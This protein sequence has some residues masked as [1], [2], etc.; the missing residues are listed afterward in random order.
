MFNWDIIERE[1]SLKETMPT[2]KPVQQKQ[3]G[4]LDEADRRMFDRVFRD[5]E[6]ARVDVRVKYSPHFALVP[7][8]VPSTHV[9]HS[10][11]NNR[12]PSEVDTAIRALETKR[13]G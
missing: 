13:S 1:V 11:T 5:I 10:T 6:A 4:H 3:D 2:N 12:K 9:K 8:W 7:G